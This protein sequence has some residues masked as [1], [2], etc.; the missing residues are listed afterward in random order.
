M[1]SG[2]IDLDG[3]PRFLRERHP[4]KTAQHVQAR[5]GVPADTVRKWLLGVAV[6]SLKTALQL[7]CA[8]GPEVLVAMFR[9]PPDWLDAEAREAEQAR[10]EAEVAAL[11]AKRRGTV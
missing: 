10:M 8:Y 5:T 9:E 1:W 3:L 6:P 7:L 2:E 11:W 4:D